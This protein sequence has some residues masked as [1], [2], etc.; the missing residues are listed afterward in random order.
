MSKITQLGVF[1]ESNSLHFVESSE[2]GLETMSHIS[3]QQRSLTPAIE[4]ISDSWEKGLSVSI[5][6]ALKKQKISTTTVNLSLPINDIIFRSF[7]IPWMQQRE[8]NNVVEFEVGKYIPFSLGELSYCHYPVTFQE[9]DKKQIRIIFVAIKNDVLNSYIRVLKGA[10][11]TVDIVEPSALSLIRALS[12]KKLIPGDQTIALIEKG[13]VG[14]I[15]VSDK[16]IPQFVREFQ[17]LGEIP[18]QDSSDPENVTKILNKEVRISLDYFNR[19]NEQ[20]KVEK[21]FFLSSSDKGN[22]PKSLE[23]HL[24]IPVAPIEISLVLGTTSQLD[25]GYLNAYG[26][27]IAPF[28]DSFASLNLSKTKV[29]ESPMLTSSKKI[30]N[31]KPFATTALICI[32]LIIGS[33]AMSIFWKQGVKKKITT[34]N[35]KLGSLQDA[36]ISFI[37]DKEK[38]WKKKLKIV[39]KTRIKS[40]VALF[41]LLIPSLL[42]EG[43]WIEALNISY[44]DIMELKKPV[45]KKKKF[46]RK[47]SASVKEAKPSLQITIIGYAYSANRG[48]QFRLV[49][50]LLGNLK[51]NKE[52]SGFFQKIELKTIKTQK[53]NEHDVTHFKILS[54]TSQ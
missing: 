47:R 30:H 13:N 39:Q 21:I 18:E 17:L 25:L 7:V 38:K 15:I 48:E 8:I 45:T 54:T 49:N 16:N 42:P 26:A 52:Y 4:G 35:E 53:I 24:D 37:E 12:S 29:E 1:W 34:L 27:S 2:T 10:S 5:K 3:F 11:L 14:R 32:P 51:N 20:L 9:D 28:T 23:S 41:M 31:Y 33:I 44:H 19:Q 50:K 6:N 40:D 22:M 46:T 36:D 43:T